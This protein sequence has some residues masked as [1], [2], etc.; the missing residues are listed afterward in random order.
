[1]TALPPA[2]GAQLA[3]LCALI[4]ACVLAMV[5]SVGHAA[6]AT[7]RD[8]S[9]PIPDLFEKL[10]PAVVT[11]TG[12]TI[13]PYRLQGRVG[14]S[15]GSGFI[16]NGD[17]LI[18]TNSHVAFG[19]Q[20]IAVTLD[21]G[22]VLPA[23]L[24]GADPIFDIAVIAIPKPEKGKLPILTPGDSDAVRVGE[25]VITIGNPLGL[26]QTIT[27]GIVSGVNRILPERPLSLSESLIQTDAPINPGN[28]GG[29]LLNRCGEVI[30][31]NTAII[32]DAQNIGF[33]IP[34][35]LIK[36]VLPSL[37]KNGRVI[38]PWIGF[39]G[40][41]IGA[42]LRKLINLP[43]VD[44]LVVEVVEP[45]SPADA[46]GIRGGRLDL[47]VGTNSIILGGDIVT[48]INGVPLSDP[49]K[50]TPIMRALKI[51]STLKLKLFRDG[52]SIDVEY[53]LPERPIMPSDLPEDQSFAVSPPHTRSTPPPAAP[54]PQK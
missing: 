10:S 38:R 53:V 18:V 34:I 30:G 46:A 50:L 23:K 52:K 31:M 22:T 27:R 54:A 14:H 12:Q 44:G 9:Q 36:A 6:T 17:G 45:G 1:M 29:P 33:A 28:S 51:G 37:L 25:D 20:S 19:Q 16:I 24:I 41:L 21:D 39:H 2:K 11:I 43:L 4:L 13:N 26:D 32:P 49:E 48:S 35:N 15:I 7:P 47:T 3:A 5:L 8:C 42:E 40:T